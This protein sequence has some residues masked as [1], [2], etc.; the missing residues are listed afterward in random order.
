MQILK[1]EN[2]RLFHVQL[3]KEGIYICLNIHE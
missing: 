2:Q 1:A 3:R